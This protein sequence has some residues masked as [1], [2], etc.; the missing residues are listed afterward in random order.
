[1]TINKKGFLMKPV[2]RNVDATETHLC[3]H[4]E[5]EGGHGRDDVDYSSGGFRTF[6]HGW[7]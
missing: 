7:V 4:V 1:M 5:M 2:E 3:E 6:V